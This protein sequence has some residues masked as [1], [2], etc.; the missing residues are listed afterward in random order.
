MATKTICDKC[1][2]GSEQGTIINSLTKIKVPKT[3]WVSFITYPKKIDLCYLCLKD[4][5]S[6][7]NNNK[8]Q[9]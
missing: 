9:R 5:F 7:I 2:A 6:Y 3:W 1:G 8:N 4:I